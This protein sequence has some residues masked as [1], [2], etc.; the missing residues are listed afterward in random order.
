M[1][2]VFLDTSALVKLYVEEKGTAKVLSLVADKDSG[3]AVILDLA[4]IESRSAIRR[5]ERDGDISGADANRILDRLESDSSSSF[6]VQPSTPAVMEEAAR[7]I[8]RYPLRAYDAIQLAAC[9]VV[10]SCLPGALRFVCADAQPCT[11]ASR[12]GLTVLNPISD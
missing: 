11:A 12:E 3:G 9:L 2:S 7:L 1:A 6:L 5:R 8:D 4:L 10:R